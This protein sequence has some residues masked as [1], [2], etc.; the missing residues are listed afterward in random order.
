MTVYK[1]DLKMIF[2]FDK[3]ELS[4]E[5]KSFIEPGL[6][7]PLGQYSAE[8]LI[9]MYRNDPATARSYLRIIKWFFSEKIDEFKK[10]CQEKNIEIPKEML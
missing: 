6:K 8:E 1:E 9:D 10:E 4:P 3:I 5:Q 2:D 7:A